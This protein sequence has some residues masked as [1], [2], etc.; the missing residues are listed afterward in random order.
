MGICDGVHT[1]ASQRWTDGAKVGRTER[2]AGTSNHHTLNRDI[3]R[4]EG[5]KWL[6]DGLQQLSSPGS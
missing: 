1:G 6:V 5:K 3:D 2:S 4:K